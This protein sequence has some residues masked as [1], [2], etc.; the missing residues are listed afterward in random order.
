MALPSVGTQP[1]VQ[2]VHDLAVDAQVDQR[3]HPAAAAA[4]V[5]ALPA[6][7]AA[8]SVALRAPARAGHGDLHG[9]HG[10]Q[11]GALVVARRVQPVARRSRQRPQAVPGALR[12]LL[13]RPPP[14][15][16]GAMATKLGK[17]ACEGVGGRAHHRRGHALPGVVHD[18]L[19]QRPLQ[20]GDLR[21]NPATS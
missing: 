1:V 19:V 4:A 8:P 20:L 9:Q 17:L 6:A 18:R 12:R 10:E 16:V 5:A 13:G 21:L 2:V 3:P 7:D 11:R 14:Q 15:Q